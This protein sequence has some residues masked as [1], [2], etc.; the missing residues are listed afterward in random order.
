MSRLVICSAALAAALASAALAEVVDVYCG[1]FTPMRFRVAAAG[2]PPQARADKAIDV[3][4]KYL[5]G[6]A[7]SITPKPEG[8]LIKLLIERDVVAVVTEA[9]AKAEKAKNARAL[10]ERWAA[11]L[12]KAFRETCAVK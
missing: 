12:N 7:P 11:S 4:N 5:G 2:L 1:S 8:K 6:K 9:D 10:A 3:I